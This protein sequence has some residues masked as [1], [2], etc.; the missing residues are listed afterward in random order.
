MD[1]SSVS[2]GV[3]VE[4]TFAQKIWLN[5]P[6]LISLDLLSSKGSPQPSDML[7]SPVYQGSESEAL[8]LSSP[9]PLLTLLSMNR[10]SPTS[11]VDA[12]QM[13]FVD[14]E[15]DVAKAIHNPS[16]LQHGNSTVG[17]QGASKSLFSEQHTNGERA[18][19]PN[20]V[21][22]AHAT[23]ISQE[24][25]HSREK[26]GL[27]HISHG[28]SQIQTAGM[29]VL[30]EG[31]MI[32][33]LWHLSQHVALADRASRLQQRVL[34][35]LGEHA[36]RHYRHQL[37]G[38]RK[39]SHEVYCS[40]RSSIAS[41]ELF[42]PKGNE[43]FNATEM[44]DG[45]GALRSL[46]LPQANGESLKFRDVQ[47]FTC[48][49]HAVLHGVL[50][51]LDS[52]ATVSS[53]DEEWD[54]EDINETSAESHCQ[55]CEWRWLAD[56]ADIC[57]RWA[58]LQMRLTELDFQMQRLEELHKNILANKGNVVLAESQPLTDKQIQHTLWTETMDLSF[59][60]RNVQDLSSDVEVEPSSPTHLLRNIERQSA[61]L[62]EIV[63]SL[64]SPL[65]ASPS[66]S[67][68]FKGPCSRWKGQ[69]KTAYSRPQYLHKAGQKRKQACHRRCPLQVDVTCVSARTRPLLTYHKPRLFNIDLSSYREQV[70]ESS[71]SLC[72]I[73]A[74]CD[75]A[76]VSTDL[77]YRRRKERTADKVHPVL[78]LSSETPSS[79]HL[80]KAFYGEN[81]LQQSLFRKSEL[82]SPH[83]C[84]SSG[85]K[86]SRSL[87]HCNHH[88]KNCRQRSHRRE[89]TPIQWPCT[90]RDHHKEGKRRRHC[91]ERPMSIC[92]KHFCSPN[93]FFLMW[94][95]TLI[96][97]R[98]KYSFVLDMYGSGVM[99]QSD[100]VS[101]TD[102]SL[103]EDVTI[104]YDTPAQQRN[105]QFPLRRRNGESI[106][107]IED[108]IVIPV[109]L[110]ASLRVERLQYKD[111]LTPSW[112]KVDISA[113]GKREDDEREERESEA[114]ADEDFSQRH[115]SYER[116]EKLG[117]S[118]CDQSRRH[119]NR[120][121]S[122]RSIAVSVREHPAHC[123][124]HVHSPV[125]FTC[126][127]G[128]SEDQ[129]EAIVDDTEPPLPWKRRVFPLSDED[130]EDLR[131]LEHQSTTSEMDQEMTTQ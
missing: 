123:H 23:I 24:P 20:G 120:I 15:R 36:T 115:Q 22:Q 83:H 128:S 119:N 63:S 108:D 116:R 46:Q 90:C 111:I 11:P 58:W 127:A 99:A 33:S 113:L 114:I 56:R 65:C 12:P 13:S 37:E 25:E 96:L 34:A 88:L 9:E 91:S 94:P 81:L 77:A 29:A 67:P 109:S 95:N 66:L 84:L 32:Q 105:S 74:S 5:L 64:M 125:P 59:T 38:L 21:L 79:L 106:F 50:E 7:L 80:Q 97:L 89:S 76:T 92:D 71:P 118:Y 85:G 30:E 19:Y 100:L 131:L 122:S 98:L 18:F 124:P 121:R 53:S 17:C 78:S 93:S 129:T 35:M 110:V 75:P 4:N 86:V 103:M 39:K 51:S 73:F 104:A 82:F 102:D 16:P 14:E 54:H 45:E 3:D 8:L 60:A 69:R 107:S 62:T 40:P 87:F 2:L 41:G 101:H 72:P 47:I 130:E 27:N 43:T 1:F 48:S 42:S 44:Q 28:S 70:L 68:V 126:N 52:D 112:Q 55:G 49:G 26:S 57:S 6:S 61:Q 117:W 10:N 31:V